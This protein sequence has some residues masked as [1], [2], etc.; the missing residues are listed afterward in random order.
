[1]CNDIFEGRAKLDGDHPR[2]RTRE[3]VQDGRL[4]RVAIGLGDQD[5]FGTYPKGAECA[6][7]VR[8]VLEVH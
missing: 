2:G 5:L 4:E 6:R 1:M 7:C 3:A 8:A